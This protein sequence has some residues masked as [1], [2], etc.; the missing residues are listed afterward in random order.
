[1]DSTTK[2]LVEEI[3]KKGYYKHSQ[4]LGK[5]GWGEIYSSGGAEWKNYELSELIENEDGFLISNIVEKI[6][7]KDDET[8]IKVFS[9][10]YHLDKMIDPRIDEKVI[11]YRRIK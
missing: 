5:G 3:L 2:M 9:E 1:M 10:L 4:T 11:S 7:A 8:A 6:M